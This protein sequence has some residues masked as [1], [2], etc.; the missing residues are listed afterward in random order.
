MTFQ[1]I[2]GMTASG[3]AGVPTYKATVV[4]TQQAANPQVDTMQVSNDSGLGQFAQSAVGLGS[5]VANIIRQK[6]G[7]KNTQSQMGK[8]AFDAAQKRSQ[9]INKGWQYGGDMTASQ[10]SQSPTRQTGGTSNGF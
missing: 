7:M 1:D 9:K 2:M 8:F 3:P 5:S 10:P 4:P 6:F